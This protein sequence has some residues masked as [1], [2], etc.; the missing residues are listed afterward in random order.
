M[1]ICNSVPIILP[2]NFLN[3]MKTLSGQHL[4][5]CLFFALSA[6]GQLAIKQPPP[7]PQSR[8]QASNTVNSQAKRF[9]ALDEHGQPTSPKTPTCVRDNRTGLIWEVKSRKPGLQYRHNT[10]TWY[11][12]DKHNNGG[13]AGHQNGGVCKDSRCDTAGYVDAINQHRLCE[14]SQ[15]RLP[16]RSEL[17]TLVNY[18]IRYPGPMLELQMF[19]NTVSQYYWSSTPDAYD[20]DSAWGIGFAYGFDYAYFKVDAARVRL[21]HDATPPHLPPAAMEQASAQAASRSSRTLSNKAQQCHPDIYA[22]TPVSRFITIDDGTLI[23]RRSGLMWMR[24]SLG[25]H[26]QNNHCTGKAGKYTLSQAR[27]IAAA[28]RYAGY[29]DWRLPTLETLSMLTELRCVSP[30][31]NLELF[32]DGISAATWTDSPFITDPR[33]QWQVEFHHGENLADV[34][35]NP[36]AVRLVRP[37]D[38]EIDNIERKNQ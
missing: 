32:P 20:K 2:L 27:R 14:L 25:Q 1:I 37:I 28:S 31:L 13:F 18:R 33:R 29:T 15:W 24:C 17:D 16:S 38:H 30:A 7:A 10:Y 22:T 34:G 26:W 19:P 4:S 21:V 12:R 23:D 5:I 9:V 6:C 35:R 11:T 3:L 36:A 8:F